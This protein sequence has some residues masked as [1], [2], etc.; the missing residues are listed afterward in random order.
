M[1]PRARC[2][3]ARPL[4]FALRCF[5][6]VNPS[7]IEEQREPLKDTALV[8]IDDSASMQL[9]DRPQQANARLPRLSPKNWRIFLISISRRCM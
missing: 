8:V 4:A 5:S 2:C 3:A 9:D 6:L 7:L 1:A